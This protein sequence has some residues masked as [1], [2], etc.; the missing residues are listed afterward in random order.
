MLHKLRN[1]LQ[2]TARLRDDRWIFANML[3]GSAASLIASF[4]LSVEAVELA[5]NPAAALSCSINVLINCATVG[6]HPSAH[7]WGFPNS[8]LGMVAEPVVI[9]VAVAGLSGIKFPRAFMAVAQVFYTLGLVFALYLFSVSYFVIG[10]LC[11]W[12]LLVTLTTTLVWFAI[13]RYNIR[14]DNLFLPKKL[15]HTLHDMIKKDVDKMV[16]WGFIVVV[17]AAIII[18]YGEGIFGS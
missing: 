1:Y 16:M 6:L 2:R 9:T 8:F 12:C 17:I 11:P 18:K 14:E 10:T 3:V 5:K 15:Q 7:L 4:V 13:T